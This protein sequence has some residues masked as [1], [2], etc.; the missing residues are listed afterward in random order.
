MF[1]N[2]L[3]NKML[4]ASIVSIVLLMIIVLT[5]SPTKDDKSTTVRNEVTGQ[6]EFKQIV[7]EIFILSIIAA[8]ILPV[9]FFNVSE[10]SKTVPKRMTL[11]EVWGKIS[12]GEIMKFELQEVE[13]ILLRG[14]YIYGQSSRNKNIFHLRYTDH[15]KSCIMNIALYVM[16][17]FSKFMTSPL[18]GLTT[19]PM[20]I[21]SAQT[22]LIKTQE[23]AARTIQTA[24]QLGI[25]KE[26]IRRRILEK[27]LEAQNQPVEGDVSE[28]ER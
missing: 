11:P 14:D 7:N 26:E 10:P 20:G 9:F 3:Q 28:N 24:E 5:I 25:T 16:D 17:D 1:D 15:N 21:E 22:R 6:K 19:M 12:R 4:K 8:V 18:V 23:T 2:I 13:S 27:E